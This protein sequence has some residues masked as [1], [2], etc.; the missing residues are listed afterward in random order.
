MYAVYCYNLNI[1]GE[2]NCF[3]KKNRVKQGDGSAVSYKFGI[4]LRYNLGDETAEPS[5]CFSV[6]LNMV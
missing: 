4:S 5:L 6:S 3:V 1:L 2:S